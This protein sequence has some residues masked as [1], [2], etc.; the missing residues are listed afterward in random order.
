MTIEGK[1]EEDKDARVRKGRM[2]RRK[3]WEG[4]EE[5]LAVNGE[6]YNKKKKMM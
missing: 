2:E 1:G 5:R 3:R 6:E 4:F